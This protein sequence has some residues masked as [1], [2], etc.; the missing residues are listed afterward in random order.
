MY[1][2]LCVPCK[3]TRATERKMLAAEVWQ[4]LMV[5]LGFFFVAL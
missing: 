2:T 1:D 4:I 3:A 5:V